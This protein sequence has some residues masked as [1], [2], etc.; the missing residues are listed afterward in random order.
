MLALPKKNFF[1]EEGKE[2]SKSVKNYQW[3]NRFLKELDQNR[4]IKTW[5]KSGYDHGL[6]I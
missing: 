2:R 3:Y 6:K 1:G 5:L 4:G